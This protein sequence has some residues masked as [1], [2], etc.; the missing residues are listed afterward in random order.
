M[1]FI[2]GLVK[3]TSMSSSSSINIQVITK[4]VPPNHSS[5]G[6]SS[7]SELNGL[8]SVS[9]LLSMDHKPVDKYE[10]DVQRRWLLT[11][12]LRANEWSGGNCE[13]D[14]VGSLAEVAVKV[15]P[16]CAKA[17]LKYAHWCY[18]KATS[19]LPPP[20]SSSSSDNNFE[21]PIAVDD[22]VS[23]DND[24][25][26]S[27]TT[28]STTSSS[29]S[30]LFKKAVSAYRKFL[31][32][33]EGSN[34]NKLAVGVA[35]RMV[36]LLVQP[37]EVGDHDWLEHV[38]RE[39]ELTPIPIWVRVAPQ[40][41]ARLGHPNP[42]VADEVLKVLKKLGSYNPLSL[43]TQAVV[44]VGAS[45]KP[46]TKSEVALHERYSELLKSLGESKSELVDETEVG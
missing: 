46:Q 37:S 19:M 25:T 4:Q 43:V 38:S 40:L 36:Q 12:L 33:A 32:L 5:N 6:S 20:S 41:L 26:Q 45:T 23:G 7:S 10:L 3:E 39:I 16:G 8:L 22:G 35:L 1:K 18:D 13:I 17:W 24:E 27:S 21:A 11:C 42:E 2:D 29:R 15:S 9:D 31:C 30:A 14:R 34:S 28:S 44:A